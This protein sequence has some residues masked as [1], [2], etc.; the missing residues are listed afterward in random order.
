MK[1]KINFSE[2]PSSAKKAILETIPGD[3]HNTKFFHV[4]RQCGRTKISGLNVNDP[5]YLVANI[6]GG[7]N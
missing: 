1:S 5:V 7:N 6:P 4:D 2:I 3:V